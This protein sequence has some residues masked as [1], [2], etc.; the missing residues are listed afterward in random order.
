MRY[1]VQ[2]LHDPVFE[3]DDSRAWRNEC[4]NPGSPARLGNILDEWK[5]NDAHFV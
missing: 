4:A 1:E 3:A 5:D 2:W